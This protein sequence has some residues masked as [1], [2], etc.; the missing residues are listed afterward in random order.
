MSVGSKSDRRPARIDQIIPA[1]VEHDAVSNHTFSAQRLLREMGFQSEIYALIIGPGCEGRVRPL[2]EIER[3][4]DGSQWVLYQCSIGSPAADAVAQHPGRKLLD[5][6]NIVPE[7]LVEKWLPPLAEESRLGRRQLAALASLV[8]VAFA[9]SAFNAAEL[10]GFGYPSPKVVPV[11]VESGNLRADPDPRALERFRARKRAGGT[12]WLFVGQIGPH[13]AQHDLI[14][15]FAVYRRAYDADA[16]LHIVGREMGT[17]YIDALRR[18]AASLGLGDAVEFPGSVPVGTLAAYYESAD[19]FVC[20]SNH[21]GFCAPIV[22]AMARGTPVVAFAAAAVPE[23]LGDAGVLLAEKP[24]ELVASVVHRLVHD[25]EARAT[26][27]GRGRER[28]KRYDPDHAES[29]FRE[30]IDSALDAPT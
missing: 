21:E 7:D 27:I 5:Y 30:L 28:A 12:D 23:T 19:A 8:S 9:D 26:F 6:H 10:D 13:K 29:A 16:R 11:L 1:I 25:D 3:H 22:E 18:F 15:A 14:K 2:R 17:I 20:L 24:P 4:R